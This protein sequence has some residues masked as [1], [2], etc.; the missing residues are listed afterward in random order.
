MKTDIAEYRE[1]IIRAQV[2]IKVAQEAVDRATE[3]LNEVMNI[4]G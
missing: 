2:N 4:K 1:A 3:L